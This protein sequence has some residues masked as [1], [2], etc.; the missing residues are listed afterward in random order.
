MPNV[1]ILD[2]DMTDDD[3]Y[4]PPQNG[5]GPDY[6]YLFAAPDLAK[7]VKPS[8]SNTAREYEKKTAALLKAG[9]VGAINA[10]Q[11]PDA[12]T[13]IYHGPGF[14]TA[15]GQ[16]ADADERAKKVIDFLTTPANPYAMFL[17]T[18]IP[19]ITQLL[20]N[21]ETEVSA[22]KQAFATRKERKTAKKAEREAR[23]KLKIN[24]PF[25]RTLTL[26]IRARFPVGKIL[27][28]FRSQTT[29]PK[30]LTINVF[31]D[32]KVTE[33]LRKS[34]VNLNPSANGKMP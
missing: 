16:L 8:A 4:P 33:Y 2:E 19:M 11:F 34:G 23:P 28:S 5:N 31:S 7:F 18:A 20:R 14:S 25:G 22:G 27:A 1:N 26:G 24:L 21:H 12:A 13:L 29:D 15:V 3:E 6:T 9:M 32:P 10:G 30:D 17:V